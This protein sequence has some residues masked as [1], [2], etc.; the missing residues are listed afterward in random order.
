M[1]S[2]PARL[3]DY[4]SSVGTEKR[5]NKII[6]EPVPNLARVRVRVRGGED[7]EKRGSDYPSQETAA[8]LYPK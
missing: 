4:C 6:M 5:A 8:F 2:K 1:R 3:P 7:D